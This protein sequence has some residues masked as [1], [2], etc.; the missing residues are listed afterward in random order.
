[1]AAPIESPGYHRRLVLAC[2]LAQIVVHMVYFLHMTPKAEGGWLLISDLFTIMLVVITL[3]GSLWIMYHL[4]TNMMPGDVRGHADDAAPCRS[5]RCAAQPSALLAAS[6]SVDRGLRRA[7]ASGSSSAA[8]G[9][10][11]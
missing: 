3:A 11:T 7:S 5:S 1:M 6:C 4:N 9:S 10:S 2:A 8:P